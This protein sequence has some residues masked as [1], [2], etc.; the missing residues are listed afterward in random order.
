MGMIPSLKRSS[1]LQHNKPINGGAR[2]AGRD[3]DGSHA[4][5]GGEREGEAGELETP[6]GELDT[7]GGPVEGLGHGHFGFADGTRALIPKPLFQALQHTNETVRASIS[8]SNC[9]SHY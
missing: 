5:S 7:C 1:A 4:E 8:T 2:H 9:L 3:E 6:S